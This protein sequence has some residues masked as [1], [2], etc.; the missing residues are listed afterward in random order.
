M[1][2]C[3]KCGNPKDDSDFSRD[4][5]RQDGLYCYCK[6][7]HKQIQKENEQK[8]KERKHQ[9]YVEHRE[10]KLF[11]QKMYAETHKE[12]IAAYNKTYQKEYFRRMRHTA[13]HRYKTYKGDA[14]RRALGFSLTF[15]EFSSFWQQPCAYCGAPMDTI[16]IDRKDNLG[17]YNSNNCVSCCPL[18]NWAKGQM[19]FADWEA[20]LIQVAA[21][22]CHGT[23][24]LAEGN[25]PPKALKRRFA[26]YGNNA[27]RK[28]IAFALD[29]EHFL[30]FKGK[31]CAY[32]GT[33]TDNIGIDRVNNDFGYEIGNCVPCCGS[34]NSGKSNRSRE[35][36][37]AWLNRIANRYGGLK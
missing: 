28:G 33:A 23:V 14:K 8:I 22:V 6:E 13:H 30:E 11:Q 15:E 1:K 7:C 26:N 27:K 35:E 4:R 31:P 32:C 2:R 16:G 3:A 24:K 25:C 9:H 17:H 34:C 5:S 37:V 20:H 18:C 36:W 29:W 21:F 10:D 12:Q 19:A